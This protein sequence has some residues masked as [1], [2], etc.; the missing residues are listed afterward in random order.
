MLEKTSLIFYRD[1]DDFISPDNNLLPPSFQK[2]RSN[3]PQ[4]PTTVSKPWTNWILTTQLILLTETA[5]VCIYVW[6]LSHYKYLW[7]IQQGLK[8]GIGGPILLQFPIHRVF[9]TP[10]SNSLTPT[11]CPTF[12]L[13]TDTTHLVVG[14]LANLALN[15]QKC[16]I[17]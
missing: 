1:M 4:S 13:N 14:G 17:W 5:R 9:S 16:Q 2:A 12:H 8:I 11:G 7:K 6:C 3:E 10:P 15:K